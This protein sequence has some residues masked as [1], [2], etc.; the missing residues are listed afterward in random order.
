MT[1]PADGSAARRRQ[2][3][4]LLAVTAVLGVALLLWGADRFARSSAET[5][6][7]GEIQRLAGTEEL[8]RVE[9]HGS[10]FLLQALTGEYDRVDVGLRG[11]SSGALRIDE[12]DARLSGVRLPFSELLRRDPGILGVEEASARSVLTYADLDRY[13]D[14][15]GRPFTVGPG[16]DPGEV[17]LRGEVR[18]LGREYEVSAD[19]VLG[20]EAGA[21]TVT[22]VRVDAGT[23]LGRPAELLL[24]QRLTVLVPL[25]PLPFGQQVTDLSA[26]QGGIVIR[27]ESGALALQPR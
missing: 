2:D 7:A 6:V 18:V 13:L 10:W 4:V 15:T 3:R 20:A 5:L 25:D 14:F 21:L 16:S 23:D 12:I 8:P 9:L 11:P 19:A 1:A 26:D 22:P 24:Q 17:V 27:T